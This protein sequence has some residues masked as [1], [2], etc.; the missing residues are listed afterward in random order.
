VTRT[1]TINTVI[2]LPVVTTYNASFTY[3]ATDIDGGSTEANFKLR[4]LS[5]ATWSA[6]PGG[7]T[8]DTVEPCHYRNGIHGVQRLRRR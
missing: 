1:W 4:K 2:G 6:P 7:T 8:V 5:G 3:V